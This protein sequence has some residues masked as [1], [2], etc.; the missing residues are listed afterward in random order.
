MPNTRKSTIDSMMQDLRMPNAFTPQL[1]K[2]N[3][4]CQR[5]LRK[6]GVEDSIEDLHDGMIVGKADVGLKKG[7]EILLKWPTEGIGFF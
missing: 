3:R 4:K 6:T 7:V 1:A 2:A 5:Q